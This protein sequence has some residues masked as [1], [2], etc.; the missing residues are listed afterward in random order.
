MGDLVRPRDCR[1]VHMGQ[2]SVC[3]ISNRSRDCARS[4]K[5]VRLQF[6]GRSSVSIENY[7]HLRALVTDQKDLLGV[8][9]L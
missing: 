7:V 1:R 9:T 3:P 8:V 4:Y 5:R 6:R 2:P